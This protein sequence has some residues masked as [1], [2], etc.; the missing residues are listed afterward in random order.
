MVTIQEM[1]NSQEAL[2]ERLTAHIAELQEN[3]QKLIST[4]IAAM[5]RCRELWKHEVDK[6]EGR[7]VVQFTRLKKLDG[8]LEDIHGLLNDGRCSP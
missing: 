4:H 5:T 3:R 8:L 1:Q 2:I 7:L 6:L